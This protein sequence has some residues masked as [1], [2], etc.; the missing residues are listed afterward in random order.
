MRTFVRLLPRLLLLGVAAAALLVLAERE[1]SAHADALPPITPPELPTVPPPPPVAPPT[2]P[3]P[4]ALPPVTAPAPP[5]VP[6]ITVPVPPISTPAPPTVPPGGLPAPAEPD[7]PAAPDV[8][9]G[10]GVPGI[11]PG[12]L[13]GI[14]GPLPDVPE[15]STPEPLLPELPE[16]P[17]PAIPLPGV[18]DL[19]SA[20]APTAPLPADAPGLAP[21][22]PVPGPA[23]SRVDPTEIGGSIVGI[24]V[25]VVTARAPPTEVPGSP[26]PCPGGGSPRP[27]RTDPA[28]FPAPGTVEATRRAGLLAEARAYASA[29]LRDPLLRPD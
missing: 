29:L 16:I 5:V 6:S 2:L 24:E 27:T 28:A 3:E 15:V 10:P 11:D 26:R 17:D 25:G 19:L 1:R 12:P 20:P 7:P 22:V 21:S 13:T 23:P 8:P 9:A 4:P 18:L 14:V